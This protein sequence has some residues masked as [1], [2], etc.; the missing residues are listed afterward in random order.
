M[1]KLITVLKTNYCS[2]MKKI[3]SLIIG[4]ICILSS[5]SVFSQFDYIYLGVGLGG[6]NIFDSNPAW[7]P[8]F[9]RTESKIP[10]IG[11]GFDG[12]ESG[13]VIKGETNLDQDGDFMIPFSFEYVWLN[14]YEV[15]SLNEST[16]YGNGHYV[17]QQK[18]GTGLNY[19]FYTFPMQNVRPFVG[20]EIKGNFINNQLIERRTT[21][22]RTKEVI[23]DY[24]ETKPAVFRLGAEVKAGFRGEVTDGFFLNVSAGIEWLNLMGRDDLRGELLTPFSTYED[25]ES[26]VPQYHIAFIIEYKL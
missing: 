15:F 10:L 8:Y 11:G 26:I 20:F 25:K 9:D 23:Y 22:V 3:I 6:S 4:L 19:Y 12:I 2:I 17:N 18:I 13:V 16:R 1:K 5:E 21:F 14:S 7:K 24:P